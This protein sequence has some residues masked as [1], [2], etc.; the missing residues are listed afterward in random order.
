MK[1]VDWS[2]L[3]FPE[4]AATTVSEVRALGMRMALGQVSPMMV[5]EGGEVCA[6]SQRDPEYPVG[7]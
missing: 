3:V 7:Q 2:R 6:V 4:K 1:L 5:G